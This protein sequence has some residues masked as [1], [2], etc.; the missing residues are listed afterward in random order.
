VDYDGREKL[1]IYIRDTIKKSSPKLHLPETG[2]IYDYLF[3][4]KTKLFTP[5]SE[6]FKSFEVD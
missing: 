3:N 6:Q 4:E 5:W 1:N 2:T